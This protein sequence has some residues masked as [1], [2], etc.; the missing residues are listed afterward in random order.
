M[1]RGCLAAVLGGTEEQVANQGDAH[2]KRGEKNVLHQGGALFE[3]LAR[4][5][6]FIFLPGH[7]RVDVFQKINATLVALPAMALFV[8]ARRTFVAQRGMASRA[9]PRDVASFGAAFWALHQSILQADAPRGGTESSRCAHSVN[10][11]TTGRAR[12]HRR[13][14]RDEGLRVFGVRRLAAAVFGRS[15]LRPFRSVVQCTAYADATLAIVIGAPP[16]KPG[17]QPAAASRRIPHR[18]CLSCDRAGGNY[19]L[20]RKRMLGERPMG[21]VAFPPQAL[22]DASAGRAGAVC[23]LA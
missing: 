9:K 2:R 14:R 18:L 23:S 1:S 22:R 7:D 16:G 4:R 11:G 15:L 10:P 13:I 17:R 8:F 3:P 5:I 6:A 20:V 19:Q 21:F 12:C